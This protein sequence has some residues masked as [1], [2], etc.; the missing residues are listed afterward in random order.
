MIKLLTQPMI[1][2]KQFSASLVVS[3][4]WKLPFWSSDRWNSLL[5]LME[6]HKSVEKQINDPLTPLKVEKSVLEPNLLFS[7]SLKKAYQKIRHFGK[8]RI[9]DFIL[10]K[11]ED[12]LIFHP[13]IFLTKNILSRVS[14]ELYIKT[15]SLLF[16]YLSNRLQMF[17]CSPP[18]DFL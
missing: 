17:L 13:K 12:E 18:V 4:P 15:R 6:S 11:W 7:K 1:L 8:P 9:N 3:W 16:L 10:A 14:C 2:S 5:D